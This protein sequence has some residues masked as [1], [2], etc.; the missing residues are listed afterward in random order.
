MYYDFN[1]QSINNH[2]I[3]NFETL[4]IIFLKFQILWNLH[5][6]NLQWSCFHSLGVDWI[7]EMEHA[8]LFA[9]G[10]HPHIKTHAQPRNLS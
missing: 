3:W 7:V 10:E 5:F 2:D 4:S 8:R 6:W 9:C 1:W